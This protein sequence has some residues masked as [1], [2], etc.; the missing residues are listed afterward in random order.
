ME[1]YKFAVILTNSAGA[2]HRSRSSGAIRTSFS[3]R[4]E[5]LVLGLGLLLD[6]LI[7]LVWH[8]PAP[9]PLATP[10]PSSVGPALLPAPERCG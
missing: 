2:S 3:A 6:I 5:L 9:P 8:A 1:S 10:A 4:L 7:V